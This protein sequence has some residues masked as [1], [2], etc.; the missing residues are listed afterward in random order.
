MRGSIDHLD[1]GSYSEV[2]DQLQRLSD[3]ALPVCVN[4]AE[5]DGAEKDGADKDGADKD[6]SNNADDGGLSTPGVNC[7]EVS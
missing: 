3:K 1:S 4:R 2:T 5:K 7:R 6:G